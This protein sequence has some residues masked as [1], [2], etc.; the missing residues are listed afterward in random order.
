MLV[1]LGRTQAP[2]PFRFTATDVNSYVTVSIA[3]GVPQRRD[4]R[5]AA[6]KAPGLGVTPRMEALGEPVIEVG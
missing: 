5:M 1:N 3:E 2:A 6:S 4:G